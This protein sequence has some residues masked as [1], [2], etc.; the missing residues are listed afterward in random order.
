[1]GSHSLFQGIFPTQGL[2]PGL[3]HCRWILYRL[4][5]QEGAIGQSNQVRCPEKLS[6]T[7]NDE[8]K[9]AGFSEEN[10]SSPLLPLCLE[11]KAFGE[12]GYMY[13]YG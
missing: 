5:C 8:K 9:P 12:N 3:L 4:S 7:L 2:N 1:M 10:I 13:M 11:T 6:R